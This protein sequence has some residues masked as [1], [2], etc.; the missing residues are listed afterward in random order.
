MHCTQKFR[1][2]GVQIQEC[3]HP[4]RSK[5]RGTLFTTQHG[6][7]YIQADVMDEHHRTI[8]ECFSNKKKVQYVCMEFH[9]IRILLGIRINISNIRMLTSSLCMTSTN[10]VI[11]RWLQ[12]WCC[13]AAGSLG[14][15]V[16]TDCCWQ[17]L[18]TISSRS[19][20]ASHCVKNGPLL[21][22]FLASLFCI[23]T[24][25]VCKND[26]FEFPAL[27]ITMYQKAYHTL[28]HML[29]HA[30]SMANLKKYIKINFEESCCACF[31][32]I[33]TKVTQINAQGIAKGGGGVQNDA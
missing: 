5:R 22:V 25:T 24:G 4:F 8:N 6:M 11:V 20:I 9:V 12:W 13:C 26:L 30:I 21:T 7:M 33:I 18:V 10:K 31:V 16:G 14:R 27:V 15:C 17:L 3:V 23:W 19:E 1:D 28:Y 29:W 2:H 32:Q